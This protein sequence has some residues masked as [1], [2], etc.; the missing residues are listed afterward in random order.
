[1]LFVNCAATINKCPEIKIGANKTENTCPEIKIGM[2]KTDLYPILGYPYAVGSDRERFSESYQLKCNVGSDTYQKD[3]TIMHYYGKVISYTERVSSTHPVLDNAWIA[4]YR[5]NN[6]NKLI[7]DIYS[8][9]NKD[10]EFNDYIKNIQENICKQ[11]WDFSYY[12]DKYI[13]GSVEV[14]VVINKDGTL[15]NSRVIHGENK[16]VLEKMAL[17]AINHVFPAKPFS[18]YS[19]LETLI[20]NIKFK[21][22]YSRKNIQ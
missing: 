15:N 12:E 10:G 22:E 13:N 4:E 14:S 19:S 18:G 9:L 8:N 1:L 5:R 2:K 6:Y 16:D 17:S 21:Y 7:I 20:I 3:I 11:W